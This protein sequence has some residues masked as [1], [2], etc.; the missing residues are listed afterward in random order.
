MNQNAYVLIAMEGQNFCTAAYDAFTLILRNAGS[1]AA[2]AS[3]GG[4]F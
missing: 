3:I 4:I 1:F 2:N